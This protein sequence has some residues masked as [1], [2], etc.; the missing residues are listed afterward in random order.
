[1]KLK[2]LA[3]A[4]ALAMVDGFFLDTFAFT[5]AAV[6][7]NVSVNLVPL[8][9][10]INFYSAL[11]NGIGFSFLPESG[12]ANFS[13]QSMVSSD[14]PLLLQVLGFSGDANTLTAA[15]GSYRGTISVATAAAVPEPETIAL[16]L[17]GLA[18]VGYM[19]RRK[20]QSSLS[21]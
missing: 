20:R 21:R 13:F 17:T 11:L 12:L 10:S 1:M 19:G 8:D 14:Q 2:M 4:A 7:G 15:A 9:T 16:L 3:V 6:S 5:P 18:F